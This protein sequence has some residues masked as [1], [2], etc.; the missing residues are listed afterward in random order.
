MS[1]DLR[2]RFD[3]QKEEGEK[4][5]ATMEDLRGGDW[6][7]LQDLIQTPAFEE[8]RLHLFHFSFEQTLK[9]LMEKNPNLDLSYLDAEDELMA[10]ADLTVKVVDEEMGVEKVV[11]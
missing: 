10:D 5:A 7:G 3:T 8:I 9:K 4:L 2:Q 11:G 1:A 6:S